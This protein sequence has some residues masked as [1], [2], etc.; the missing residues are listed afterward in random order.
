MH[1]HQESTRLQYGLVDQ[2][3][4]LGWPRQRIEVIDEDLGCSGASAQGRPGFQRLVAEVGLDHVGIVLG[5]EMSRLSRSSRDWHQLLEACAIFGTLIGDLDGVYDPTLYN[6]RLLLGLKGTMSEAELHILKQRMLEGKRAKARRGELGMQ[7]PMGYVRH[8]SGEVIKDPD[9]Q[10]QGVI[11]RVFDVFERKRTLNGVLQTFVEQR[12]QMPCRVAHGPNKGELVWR[13]PNRTTLSNL[14][15]N[16]IYAGAYVYGR[17]PTDVRKKIPG[18]PSTG[19]TVATVGEWEVLIKDRLPA[20][21]RWERYERNLAQLEANRAQAMGAVRQGPSLLSG[22]LV[23]GRCGLRMG[24]HYSSNGKGLR[25]ACDRMAIDYGEA[26]CQALGGEVLDACITKLIMQALEPSSLEISLQV[27]EDIEG[28]RRQQQLHWQ[29]RL[30]RARIDAERAFRQYN[31]VEPENR[32]VA[33]T[34]ERQWETALAFSEQLQREYEEFLVGQPGILTAEERTAIARLA[35]D[36]PALW[37]APTTT[38][39]DRQLIARQL[40]EG[41]VVTVIDDT[42]QVQIE[43]RWIGGHTTRT[44]LIRP[45]AR[46]AQMSGYRALLKRVK[47]LQSE[48]DNAVQI[49]RT[50]NA[51]GWRPP[52]RRDTYNASMVRSLLSRQGLGTGTAKQQHTAGIERQ[53]DEWTLKELAGQLAMPEPTLYSWLRKG[54][55]KTRRTPVATRSIWLVQADQKELDR[56]RTQRT[57]KQFWAQ[58]TEGSEL[59]DHKHS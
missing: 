7:V 37:K 46:M 16:P 44:T 20:Y 14:L 54:V 8:L 11:L 21:I 12:I 13:R 45:V 15:H 58:T 36:I 17:R 51:E 38:A 50:L 3:L 35:E 31:A 42:E 10:A 52:K 32:L 39:A 40:I 1:R 4:R 34:L 5:L 27:A 26:R 9:E 30:E 28:E 43:V 19:R 6:D 22:L 23:C 59:N 47:A 49:A 24:T 18:R 29:Q 53:P 33:R 57:S 48:G 25:Y 2:A 56:L 55:L 41:V